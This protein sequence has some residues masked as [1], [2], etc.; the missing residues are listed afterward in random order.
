MSERRVLAPDGAA[1]AVSSGGSGPWM[2]LIPGLGATR[3]VFDPLLPHL[4]PSREVVVYDQRGIGASDL[5]PGPYSTDQLAD[6]A[7]TVL[8]GLD[9]GASAVLG[10]SFGGMVATQMAV[11]H[12]AR[13]RSLVLAATSPGSGHLVQEPEPAARDA[14]LGR[15]AR[16]PEEAY[17]I[18]CTVLYSQRF[19]REHADFVEDQV[20]ERARR[21]VVARAFQAQWQASRQHDAWEE[22]PSVRV[23]TLVIHGEEDAVMPAANARAMAAR[24]PG[25][26][27]VE[28]EGAGHLF[29]H[30]QP[31][32]AAQ[33]VLDFTSRFE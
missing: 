32:R 2:L 25:A 31:Q 20:R 15:G 1:L 7:A 16:S 19:Q 33:L 30:E 13:V 22:L 14:L 6:D 10:A 23:P 21:P 3:V 24:I 12:P 8:D 5:T 27:Y 11:R 4:T 26:E 9:I 29:F 18:A 28:L 17:R